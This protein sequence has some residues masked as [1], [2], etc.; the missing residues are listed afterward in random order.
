MKVS[1]IIPIYNARRFVKQ[2]VQSALQQLETAEIILIEDG[3]P[4]ESLQECL[5]LCSQ[6]EKVRVLQHPGGENR[7]ASASRNLGIV[8]AQSEYIAFL[9]ADDFYLPDRFAVTQA[10]F[11]SNTSV[12]GVYE[13]VECH[14]ET[15]DDEKKWIKLGYSHITTIKPGIPPE[16]LFDEHAPVGNGGH[17]HLNGLTLNKDVIKRVGFFDD[18]L[19]IGQD[20]AFFM[21]LAAYTRLMSGSLDKSVAKR[22]VHR[23][24]RITQPRCVNQ[25]WKDTI[26]IWLS[27]LGWMRQQGIYRDLS[28]ERLVIRKILFHT[29]NSIPSELQ[30]WKQIF[31]YFQRNWLILQKAP[32]LLVNI[33]FLVRVFKNI[34]ISQTYDKGFVSE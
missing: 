11:K 21:K 27:V 33:S 9:D 30:Y 25:E 3:S 5:R 6:H 16:R 18:E 28:Q 10:V 20:T 7:G 31:L 22:R 32:Y 13:A 17:C 24:N 19:I 4:D 34:G 23:N 29:K 1:V 2:A 14:F 15:Q 26:K 12:N 8:N